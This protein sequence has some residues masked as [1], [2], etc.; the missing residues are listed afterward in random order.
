MRELT[1]N[2]KYFQGQVTS[3]KVVASVVIISL[4]C[5]YDFNN[6]FFDNNS[7]HLIT[8][9][10]SAL[11]LHQNRELSDVNKENIL[12]LYERYKTK[13]DQETEE[14][15]PGLSLQEQQN[16]QG[17]LDTFF[18]ESKKLKLKAVLNQVQGNESI[19]MALIEIYDSNTKVTKVE[20]FRNNQDVFGYQLTIINNTQ[21]LLINSQNE[22]KHQV[23]LSMYNV[24]L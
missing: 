13:T 22:N 7:T 6:R 17:I 5:L 15:L 4:V 18:I 14:Q 9:E 2:L 3:P 16:Q 11:P 10:E 8:M 12:A 23:T 1:L 21:V 19:F 24:T 20:T